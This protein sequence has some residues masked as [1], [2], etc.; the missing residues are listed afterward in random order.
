M[1]HIKHILK[2]KSK[3]VL[4]RMVLFR[5]SYALK[6][7]L[8]GDSRGGTTSSSDQRSQRLHPLSWN[9]RVWWRERNL[10]NVYQMRQGPRL[11]AFHTLVRNNKLSPIRL[12]IKTRLSTFRL[13]FPNLLGGLCYNHFIQILFR[14]RRLGREAMSWVP[15]SP[16]FHDHR[17]FWW[18]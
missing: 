18:Q 13:L 17:A 11:C 4:T 2:I 14:M 1:V 9:A 10:P 3:S 5:T 8:W 6:Q 7:G 16:S 15:R 12:K